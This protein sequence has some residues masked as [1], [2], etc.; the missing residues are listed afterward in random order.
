[1]VLLNL[2]LIVNLYT[3]VP[4]GDAAF[5]YDSISMDI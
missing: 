5:L 1:M 3:L 2:E 4:F